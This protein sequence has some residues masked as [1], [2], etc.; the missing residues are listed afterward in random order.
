MSTADSLLD[1][2]EDGINAHGVSAELHLRLKDSV[3]SHLVLSAW[4]RMFAASLL[5][6]AV[7][8]CV[9]PTSAAESPEASTEKILHALGDGDTATLWDA[10]PEKYQAD[11]KAVV[12]EWG[13][14]I[15]AELWN[16]GFKSIAK[17]AKV[18]KEKKEFV[19]G[20]EPVKAL[21]AGNKKYVV[22]NLDAVQVT[23]ETLAASEISTLD[24]LKQLDVGAFCR[25][26]AKKAIGSLF[27]VTHPGVLSQT[28]KLRAAKVRLISTEGD[29]AVIKVEWPDEEAKEANQGKAMRVDGKW[30]PSETVLAWDEAIKGLKQFAGKLKP[31]PEQKAQ[32]SALLG[33]IDG[34]LV[35]LAAAK[36][37]ATFDRELQSILPLLKAIGGPP[38][39]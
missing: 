11:I 7:L 22:D 33:G 1:I 25:G 28:S 37:Q 21:D 4:L 36:D 18:L 2:V 30:L 32:L 39:P 12:A 26:S 23:F 6:V 5:F 8:G 9:A 29:T 20:S 15:D 17:L 14:N 13:R 34:V 35:R 27:G 24:G 16:A 19:I 10:L 38:K 31:E 3:V